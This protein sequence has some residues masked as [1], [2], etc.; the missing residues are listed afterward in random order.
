MAAQD[1]C[2]LS[3]VRAFLELPSGDTGRDTLITNTITP[4]SDAIARYCQREFVPT[5]SATRTFRLD[6]GSLKVDLAPYDLRTASTVSLH[7][8]SS[9][10][11]TLTANTQYQLQ[12]ITSINGTYTSIRFASN[13]ANIFQSDSGRFFGY[14]QFSIAGAWGFSAIPTDVKQAAIIAVASAVRKDVPALDIG[15][16]LNEPRQLTP[17]R[18]INYALPAATLRMLSPYRR[19]SV[20]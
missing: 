17:E 16:Y 11:V 3:D 10:P 15:D 13:I 9:S 18:P 4:I 12:P 2:T 5:A 1:L 14:A 20:Q 7:P 6:V 19:I 8:E